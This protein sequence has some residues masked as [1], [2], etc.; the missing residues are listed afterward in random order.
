MTF[1]ALQGQLPEF[2]TNIF[3][4]CIN[5]MYPL[6]SNNCKLYLAEKPK[7]DFLKKSFSYRGAAS[8][9]NNLPND[10]TNNYKELSISNFKT[11]I[12]NYFTNMERN[13]V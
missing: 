2:M 7:T 6:T 8:W 12:N 4:I 11:L 3:K 10:V 13:S 5:D 1:K 9:N